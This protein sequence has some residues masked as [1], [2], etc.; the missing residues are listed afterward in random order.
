MFVVNANIL[1]SFFN[2]R[3]DA[4]NLILFSP[5]SFKSPGF[6]TNALLKHKDL[7]IRKFSLNEY[8]FDIL[9]NLLKRIIDFVPFEDFKNFI[10]EA[11]ELCPHLKDIE[12]FALALN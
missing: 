1:F 5:I 9:F 8:S 2:K 10:L 3:S 4:R 6:A 11:A 12:Y 7:I